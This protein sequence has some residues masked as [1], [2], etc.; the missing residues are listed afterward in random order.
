MKIITIQPDEVIELL[1]KN[2]EYCCSEK[3][4]V[5]PAENS[6]VFIKPYEWMANQMIKRNILPP[7]G[8]RFPIWGWYRYNNKPA[9][10]NT[11]SKEEEN[12]ELNYIILDIPDEQ[13]LLSDFDQWHFVLNNMWIDDSTSKKEFDENSRWFHRLKKDE[14]EII[15][16]ESWQKIFDITPRKTGLQKDGSFWCSYGEY[17]QAT[18]WKITENMIVDIK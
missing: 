10:I 6:D 8:V 5:N 4:A 11:I 3:L 16:Q 18:F 13:V 2:G 15:K 17:V 1:N 7:H 14:Q 12:T 9:E